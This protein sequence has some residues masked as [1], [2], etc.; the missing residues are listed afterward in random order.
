LKGKTFVMWVNF[1]GSNC[2]G[3][4]GLRKKKKTMKCGK[5]PNITHKKGLQSNQI[6]TFVPQGGLK[7]KK[8]KTTK[9]GESG[10]P[11]GE[12]ESVGP[13]GVKRVGDAMIQ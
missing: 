4:K 7:K 9:K 10:P 5:K 3:G 2:L 11:T 13:G 12:K 1:G 8:K 6:T